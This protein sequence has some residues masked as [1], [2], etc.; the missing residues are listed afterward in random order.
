MKLGEA[1][2]LRAD[3]QKRMHQVQTRLFENASVQEGDAPT[4]DPRALL[5]EHRAI[6]AE[7]EQLVRRINRTNSAVRIRVADDDVTLADAVL[8][9]DRLARETGLLRELATRAVPSRNRFLRTQVKHVPTV[10]VAGVVAEADALSKAHRELDTR[11][12]QSNWEADL[13]D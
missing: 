3:L 7:H 11:I 4:I 5:D 12:Q 9:R 2:A 6:A 10:D 8:R 1:L 13:I